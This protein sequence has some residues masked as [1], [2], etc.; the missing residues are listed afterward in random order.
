[1][2]FVARSKSKGKPVASD[3]ALE[4]GIFDADSLPEKLAFDHSRI[5]KDYFRH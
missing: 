4:V 1:V 3:D 5:L 2:V